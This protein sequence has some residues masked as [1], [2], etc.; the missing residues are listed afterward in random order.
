MT[1]VRTRDP[2]V[3]VANDHSD[4]RVYAAFGLYF[5]SRWK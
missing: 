5:L 2:G 4:Q 1:E 3:W